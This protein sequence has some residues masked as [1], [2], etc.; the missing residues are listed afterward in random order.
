MNDEQAD[1]SA[2]L[3]A[4]GLLAAQGKADARTVGGQLAIKSP[5]VHVCAVDGQVGLCRGC[6][7]TLKEI[8]TWSRISAGERD[9]IMA[10]LPERMTLFETTK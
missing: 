5:C 6:G 8:A 1:R 7:R 3:T 9:T 2:T 10:I 4:P